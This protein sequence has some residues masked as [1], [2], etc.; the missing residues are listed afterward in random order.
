MK[1]DIELERKILFAIEENYKPG[2]MYLTE[3]EL[4]IDDYSMELIA[5]HCKLLY[6][7]G[8]IGKYK[9]DLT[10]TGL[11]GF[12]IENLT[13]KGYDYLEIIRN[14]DVWEKTKKEVEDKKL[15]KTIEF[16]A[17]IAGIFTGNIINEMN[18]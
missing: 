11:I 15:P 5:E 1:R 14:D 10:I 13:A 7:Q 18:P 6:Q 8:L 4:L 3:D 17:K 12:Q 16:L 9:E 2:E